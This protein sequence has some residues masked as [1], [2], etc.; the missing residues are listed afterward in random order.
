M[1]ATDIAFVTLGCAKNEVDTDKMKARLLAAGYSIVDDPSAAALVIV[2]TCSF[3]V[4]AVDE[5]LDVIF[6]LL[7][8]QE[9]Q[10]VP[11]KLLVAGCMPARYGRDLEEELTEAAGFLSA[12]D[13]E[14]VVEK[15]EEVLGV[16]P[17]PPAHL[18][19]YRVRAHEG[20][21]AYVKVSDGCDRFCTYCMIPYIRGRYH[22]YP[23]DEILDEVAELEQRGVRE[24]V[25]IGQ[26][27]GLWGTDLEGGLGL[28]D[29]LRAAAG[30]FPGL[31]FRVLYLQPAGV[32]DELLD[33]MAS[34]P[35]ICPYLDIPL[36]HADAQVLKRMNR[37]GS[38][39]EYLELVER[40]RARVPG[41]TLRTTL[42]AGFPG[43]TDEQFGALLDFVDEA[44]FDYAV[45][46]PYST[47]EGSAAAR[48]EDQV[49]DDLRIER[50]QRLLDAC[51]AV[52]HKRIREHI[53]EELDVLVEGFE[54]TEV[55][56][57]ALCRWQGQAPEVDGQVHV[58]LRGG[59]RPELGATLQVRITDSFCYDLEG[60][61]V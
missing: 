2:N 38:S 50:A 40:I 27:T 24:V 28:V 31:W 43:E 34:T 26:D 48:Y 25:F 14:H 22:S 23:L 30:R 42:M 29:L 49:D 12:A 35:N 5:G 10:P 60:E 59:E 11:G 7:E 3:L 13:E 58:P 1:G 54:M 41:V 4:S 47:E 33:L 45:V 53:G 6:D 18:Q 19:A 44:R 21:S 55:G 61:L 46:F 9:E 39:E 15:V 56:C 57:E 16:R 8:Q 52:G 51:D 17:E 36:Q 20:P 37:A 32:S